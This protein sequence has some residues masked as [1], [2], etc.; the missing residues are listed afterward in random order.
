MVTVKNDI[1]LRNSNQT[2]TTQEQGII[3]A[4]I[5]GIMSKLMWL[6]IIKFNYAIYNN[7]E[8]NKHHLTMEKAHY[9]NTNPMKLKPHQLLYYETI[10][11]GKRSKQR[12]NNKRNK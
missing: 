2:G 12:N 5:F 3:N 6:K 10:L 8:N 11:T 4:P 7:K 1:V 9:H